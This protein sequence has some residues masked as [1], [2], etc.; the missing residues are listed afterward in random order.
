MGRR[1][2]VVDDEPLLVRSL[3]YALEREGYL[4]EVAADGQSAVEAA[5]T[6]PLDLILL[7]IG[8]PVLSGTD[9]C[10]AIREQSDVPIIMVTA[11]DSE[12]DVVLGLEAGADD[13]VTKPFS[14]SELL[15]RIRAVL[16]RYELVHPSAPADG[17]TAT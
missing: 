4:V 8:L 13:Y 9:A 5:T 17:H 16:R 12:Q 1:V 3:E 6:H 14:T 7:D 2:L 10:I 11:R 15:G